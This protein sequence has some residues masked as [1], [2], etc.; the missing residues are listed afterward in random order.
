ML[1]V[2]HSRWPQS[3]LYSL[4]HMGPGHIITLGSLPMEDGAGLIQ[5]V[6]SQCLVR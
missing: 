6:I 3:R 5:N 2:S 1:D 4:G